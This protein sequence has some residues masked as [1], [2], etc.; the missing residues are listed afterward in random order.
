MP[1]PPPPHDPRAGYGVES[2]SVVTAPDRHMSRGTPSRRPLW[3]RRWPDISPEPSPLLPSTQGGRYGE[4]QYHRARDESSPCFH[5]PCRGSESLPSSSKRCPPEGAR[6]GSSVGG[7]HWSDDDDAGTGSRC[8]YDH[9]LAY[10]SSCHR[11]HRHLGSN[12]RAFSP[13]HHG[14]RSSSV[15]H[16]PSPRGKPQL[17]LPMEMSPWDDGYTSPSSPSY[18]REVEQYRQRGL[19]DDDQDMTPDCLYSAPGSSDGSG[20]FRREPSFK[21]EDPVLNTESKDFAYDA[22]VDDFM[23]AVAKTGRNRNPNL[24]VDKDAH[25]KQT[26]R[27]AELALKRYNKNK[28][29][30][31]KYALVEAIDGGAIWEDSEIYAHVNFYAKAKNGPKK[32]DGKVLVFAELHQVGRRLNAM[33][34]TCFRFLDESN[35][36]CGRY[37]QPRNSLIRQNQDPGHCY[38]CSDIIKHPDGSCYKAGHIV[39]TLY[40]LCNYSVV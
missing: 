12:K 34:L 11:A 37:D 24:E 8:Q 3:P 2:S 36:L 18:A 29:N 10:P 7:R 35:Q 15:Q 6:K 39:C 31:V 38:A 4:H 33:V 25:E 1:P 17:P 14:G 32:H 19:H 5:S 22:L 16:R 30:K 28:N 13:R 21:Y 23:D 20:I 9:E 26:N 40:Y 27:F